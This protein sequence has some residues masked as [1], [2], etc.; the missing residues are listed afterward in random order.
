MGERLPAG[1][2]TILMTDVEGSSRLWE[3]DSKVASGL[4]AAREEI[5]RDLTR[6]CGGVLPAEQGEGDSTLSVFVRASDAA[7]CAV[8]IQRALAEALP[9]VRLRIA[10][11]TGEVDPPSDGAYRGAVLNRCARLRAI[12][13]GGQILLSEAAYALVVDAPPEGSILRGLGSHRLRDL[14]R[15]EQV[16]QLCH[17]DLPDAFP[18]LRSLHAAP[19]NLPVP[20]TSFVGRE[21]AMDAVQQLLSEHRVVTLTGAGGGGKTRLALQVATRVLDDYPDG[22]WWVDL[23]P[24][25]DPSLVPAALAAVLGIQESPLEPITETTARYLSSHR[26]LVVFDNCEHLIASSAVL[27]ERLVQRCAA[28]TVLATSREPLRVNGETVWATPPLTLPEENDAV[29]LVDCDAVRLFVDR[30]RASQSGFALTEQNAEAV[31]RICTRLDGIPLAIELAAAR[32]RLL[33][34]EEIAQGLADRFHL[35]TGGARTALPRQ[36]TLENSVGWSHDLLTDEERVVFRRVAVFAGS[37]TLEAVREVCSS[38]P[39]ASG[40][41][42]ELL[43]ALVDRSLV[44]VVEEKTNRTRYRLLESI[45]D[46]ARHKLADAGEA[47]V[48]RDSHLDY[49]VAFAERAASGMGGPDLVRWLSIV[50]G[51]LDNLRAALDFSPQSSDPD[52]GARIVG[53]LCPYWFARSELGIGRARLEAVVDAVRR[54]A[55][56]WAGALAALSWTSY[57]AGDMAAGAHHG[58]AAIAVAR[59]LGDRRS[60]ARAL[61]YRGWV[62][63]W[64]ESDHVAAWDA[65]AEADS[66]FAEIGD[67][68]YRALNLAMYGWS[69]AQSSELFRAQPLLEE[70]MA[71]TDAAPAPHARCYLHV[72]MGLLTLAEGRLADAEQHVTKAIA[73]AE[74]IGDHYAEVCARLFLNWTLLA[75]GRFE[76]A[77]SSCMHGLEIALKHRSPNCESFMRT[78][79]GTLYLYEGR[80]DDAAAELEASFELAGKSMPVIAAD[81]LVGLAA[82]ALADSK[83]DEARR[84]ADEGVRLG[85][86]VDFPA[87]IVQGVV[88]QATLAR[89]DGEAHRAEDLL[90]EALDLVYESG[91]RFFVSGILQPLAGAVA[92]QGRLDEA[93]RILSAAEAIVRATGAMITSGV[94]T[95]REAE[96]TAVRAGLALDVFDT[97]W[98]EGAS[99]SLDEAVAYARRGRGERKRPAH[100]WD[101]LTPTELQ[102]VELVVEGLTNPQIGQRLFI[103]KRTVQSH[104]ASVFAKLGVSTRTELAAKAAVRRLPQG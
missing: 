2:I 9:D 12:G 39:I 5:V 90:H 55:P 100:G 64:G 75:Y 74:E 99:L 35:L 79:L 94:E 31:G 83:L 53:S 11:H 10:L 20:L 81:C 85:R 58:D 17:P 77:H 61:H 97:A 4:L 91:H 50:D 71:L 29:S 93:A 16:W 88:V 52:R 73:L 44:Q 46:F 8:A 78:A 41:V 36:R 13:Y 14:S 37:F 104:V 33:S 54:D 69:C 18:P 34:T 96:L 49:C 56:A 1:T 15:S 45:R 84:L 43:G 26:S 51:E 38:D 42:I 21:A 57:R 27:V 23:A 103:S 32:T 19:N 66:L 28:V 47:E 60:L 101:S 80:I 67:T 70:G 62:S 22:I 3:R 24:M 30:A 7:A 65:F 72:S 86:E 95:P 6:A 25:D 48:T 40:R 98:R 68:A 92:D 82:V 59:E 63:E 102:V 89:F 76:E 87:A